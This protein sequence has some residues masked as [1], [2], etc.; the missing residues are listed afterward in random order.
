MITFYM[1]IPVE[2]DGCTLTPEQ[3]L[4]CRVVLTGAQA[5]MVPCAK[6]D[7]SQIVSSSQ[8]ITR[9]QF[10]WGENKQNDLGLPPSKGKSS[11]GGSRFG[12]VKNHGF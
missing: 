5:R 9:D 1:T 10:G 8:I 6:L 2:C 4:A 7:Y 3:A 11:A 12:Q